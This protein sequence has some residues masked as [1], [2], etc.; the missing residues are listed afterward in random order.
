[1]WSSVL[2]LANPFDNLLESEAWVGKN[3]MN[4]QMGA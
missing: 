2:E 1:M 4:S 3:R